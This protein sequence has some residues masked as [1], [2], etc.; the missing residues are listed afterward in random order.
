MR[1]VLGLSRFHRTIDSQMFVNINTLACQ[2]VIRNKTFKFIHVIKINLTRL[3]LKG[4]WVKFTSKMWI[5]WYHQLYIHNT[6]IMG[7]TMDSKVFKQYYNL[8]FHFYHFNS[9]GYFQI[10]PHIVAIE[11]KWWSEFLR[12][13]LK[14]HYLSNYWSDFV[15]NCW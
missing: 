8:Y 9:N 14:C 7:K 6:M 1:I 13:E 11:I 15:E 2:L 5:D 3:S 4:S 12:I 10:W